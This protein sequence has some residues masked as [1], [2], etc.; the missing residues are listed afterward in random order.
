M[1]KT[2]RLILREWRDEDLDALAEMGAD[3]RVMKYF[4]HT[5]SR[6]ESDQMAARL[7]GHFD[8]HGFGFWAVEATGVAPFVGFVG[9]GVP[10]FETHFTPCVEVGWRLAHDY[11]NRGYATEAARAAVAYGFDELGLSEIVAFT[12]PSNEP[13][14]RVMEKLGMTHYPA[15]DFDHP[16]VA[17]GHPLR[18]HVLYRLKNSPARNS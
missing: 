7:R 4:V 8:R 2:E 1:L 16:L 3:P 6:E 12:V 9:L 5:L 18:K 13:S 11:W 10:R 17:E 15:D 14:R